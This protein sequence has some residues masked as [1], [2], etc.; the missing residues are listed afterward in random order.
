MHNGMFD[1]FCTEISLW[2]YIRLIRCI[3]C[4][5]C[6]G[7]PSLDKAPD[8]SAT[9]VTG[10]FHTLALFLGK[11]VLQQDSQIRLILLRV[12]LRDKVQLTKFTRTTNI[13][14]VHAQS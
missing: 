1:S 2:Y 9:L 6:A 5:T 12:L 13:N 11:A 14:T 8:D 3:A 10:L 7:I 4:L